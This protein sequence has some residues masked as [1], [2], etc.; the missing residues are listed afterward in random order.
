M[1]KEYNKQYFETTIYAAERLAKAAHEIARKL[2]SEMRADISHEEFLILETIIAN[3]GILQIEIAEKILMKRSYACKLLG[4]LL[5]DG[6][7]RT[8]NAIRGKRQIVIK[9]FITEKGVASYKKV[10]FEKVRLAVF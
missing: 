1:E 9:N 2:H 4:R 5:D 10:Y 6:Y 8:E 3:P 7:I